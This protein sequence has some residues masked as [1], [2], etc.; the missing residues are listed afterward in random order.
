MAPLE[1]FLAFCE[2]GINMPTI[3]NSGLVA[4][5]W[6]HETWRIE[7]WRNA[8]SACGPIREE[9]KNFTDSDQANLHFC[10]RSSLVQDEV[11][12]LERDY[13]ESHIPNKGWVPTDNQLFDLHQKIV[14]HMSQC[15]GWLMRYHRREK[16]IIEHVD[17]D[18]YSRY[19]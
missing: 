14:S 19:Y 16:P 18:G 5:E 6:L 4:G 2:L 15:N 8:S 13:A 7:I 3:E 10:K 1:H 11:F 17:E 12:K 9:L